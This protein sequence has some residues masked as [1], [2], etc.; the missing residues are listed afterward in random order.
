MLTNREKQVLEEFIK[1]LT[2]EDTARSLEISALTAK[3]H[4]T[5]I[6]EKLGCKSLRELIKL[7]YVNKVDKLLNK[8]ENLLNRSSHI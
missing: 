5:N 6:R 8:I 4:L 3:T 1:T 7:Y 2:I